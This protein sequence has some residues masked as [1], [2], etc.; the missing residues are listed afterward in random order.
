MSV[1]F[2]AV[3]TF[4]GAFDLG[5]VQ[6][7]M[8]MVSKV[9]NQAGFG[10]D[11]CTANRHLLSGGWDT[12]A[13]APSDW[14]TTNADVVLSNPPC[15]GFS[16][17]TTSKSRGM[18]AAINNCMWHTMQYAAAMPKA[19]KALV[20]ESVQQALTQGMPLMRDLRTFLEEETGRRYHLTH[21]LQ[22]NHALGG[23][24]VRR[25]YFMVLTLEPLRL[26]QPALDWIPTLGD[27]IGDLQDQP[28]AWEPT[29]YVNRLPQ[30]QSTRPEDIRQDPNGKVDGHNYRPTENTERELE[31]LQ[32][33]G[34][35]EP[36]QDINDA[37]EWVLAKK[38]SLPETWQ[39]E[40][41]SGETHED[42]IRRMFQEGRRIHSFHALKRLRYEKQAPVISGKGVYQAFHP[43][44]DRHL[45]MREVARIMGF[46]DTWYIYPNK[47]HKALVPWWGKGVSVPAGRW[48]AAAVRAN[49]EGLKFNVPL[50]PAVLA[51]DHPRTR[52]F[53]SAERETVVDVSKPVVKRLTFA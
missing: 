49:V 38:G 16:V 15:S 4:A 5:A 27:T 42:T 10:I 19:P 6:A 9:E 39:K 43:V 35:R 1:T 14:L 13:V 23:C 33:H 51:S 24:S 26:H 50:A 45:T 44:K 22:S 34:L 48:I 18:Q 11:N 31:I 46:P 47:D 40:K 8:E 30:W 36:G 7:G 25:R 21:V 17:M 12:Q 28:L 2:A 37:L 3:Q 32:M 20:L 29:P 53:G 52:Q 41:R